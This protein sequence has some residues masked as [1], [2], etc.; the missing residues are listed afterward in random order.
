MPARFPGQSNHGRSTPT[1]TEQHYARSALFVVGQRTVF[2][3]IQLI[4]DGVVSFADLAAFEQAE[5]NVLGI[6]LSSS[7][8]T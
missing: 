6:L 3:C 2:L 1:V 4:E 7:W 8:I 5:V